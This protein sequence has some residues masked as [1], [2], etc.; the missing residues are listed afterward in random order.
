MLDSKIENKV[1]RKYAG[2]NAGR[3]TVR[4]EKQ[5]HIPSIPSRVAAIQCNHSVGKWQTS[6]LGNA[7]FAGGSDFVYTIG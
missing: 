5:N 7:C 4:E 1:F 6:P 2:G 3:S